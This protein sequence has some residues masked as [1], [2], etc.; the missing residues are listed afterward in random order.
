MHVPPA[1]E[2][3]DAADGPDPDARLLEAAPER[4]HHGPG[5][6][7]HGHDHL[8]HVVALGQREG[9]AH[10]SEH[11]HAV[12]H[13]AV[14]DGIV[15][16][17]SD[18][19]HVRCGAFHQLAS[20]GQAVLARAGDQHAVGRGEPA[21]RWPRPL[22]GFGHRP[23]TQRAHA[24]AQEQ[25][26]QHDEQE[27]GHRHPQ[28]PEPAQREQRAQHDGARH[29]ERDRLTHAGVAPDGPVAAA[30]PVRDD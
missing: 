29:A 14:L 18:Q 21:A 6:R 7:G 11:R 13:G 16:E 26:Q 9:V 1:H 4:A 3:V 8:A 20:D 17:E 2:A 5:G 10:G 22:P 27:G 30:Q 28:R 24:H 23:A 19:L 12:E 15:V 25:R